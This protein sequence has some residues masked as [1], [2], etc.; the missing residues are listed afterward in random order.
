MNEKEERYLRNIIN[1]QNY[2][3]DIHIQD[4][5]YLAPHGSQSYLSEIHT[6][7]S[8]IIKINSLTNKII[9]SFNNG[10][11][12][13]MSIDK[14]YWSPLSRENTK[15]QES[16]YYYIEN[17]IFRLISLWD[18]LAQISNIYFKNSVSPSEI[19]YKK[20]FVSNLTTRDNKIVAKDDQQHYF[21][22]FCGDVKNY[23][24]EHDDIKIDGVWKGNHT[25]VSNS[26]RNPLTHRH[27]PHQFSVSNDRINFKQHPLFELK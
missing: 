20:Y 6:I 2:K 1:Q 15:E 3:Y 10:I 12:Y 25:Y 19:M 27:D 13:C 14:V 7:D 16:C 17:G 26:I 5:I 23:I 9:Y 4:F 22:K 8:W 21:E 24:L 18:S 11:D